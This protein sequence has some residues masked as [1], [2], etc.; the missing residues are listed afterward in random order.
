MGMNMQQL[1]KQA[2]KMQREMQKAQEELASAQVEGISGG[3]MVKVTATGAQ[4]IVSISIDPE[5]VDPEDVEMLEDLV[6]AAMR[7]A[8]AASQAMAAQHLG[9]VTGGMG[10]PGMF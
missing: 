6:L 10:L 3:G 7:E 1:M 4:E 2:Q 9:K 5:I 8:S